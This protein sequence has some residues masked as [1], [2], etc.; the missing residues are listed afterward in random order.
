MKYNLLLITLFFSL[1]IYTQIKSGKVTYVVSMTPISDKRIDSIS[2]KSKIKNV[3]S[4]KWMYDILKNTPNV[5][6]Y[7][8]FVNEESM[9][10]VEDKMELDGK[11]ILNM[12][13][14]F[15]GGNNKVYKNTKT[16]EYLKENIRENLLIEKE[17]KKWQITQ[18]SKQIGKYICFKAIDIEST[19]TK[20]KPVVWF[21][22]QIPVSFGPSEYNGL[23][24][25]VILVEMSNRTI[26]ASKIV[27][28]PKEKIELKK[29]IKG[30]RITEEKYNE[31]MKALWK[32]IKKT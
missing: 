29:L 17:E 13:R 26:S 21:T 18:E 23:P 10:Y 14:I 27:L 22:P 8:D 31:K 24:G 5:N 32:S 7:L 4:K 1:A 25:L 9:Y 20:M 3:K 16:K 28:N 19:N 15:A 30:D 12:N 11:S 2:K 6:T